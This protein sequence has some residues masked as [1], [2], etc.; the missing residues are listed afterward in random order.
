M[1]NEYIK[2]E[3]IPL[4]PVFIL[5]SGVL[6]ADAKELNN[7]WEYLIAAIIGISASIYLGLYIDNLERTVSENKK[8]PANSQGLSEIPLRED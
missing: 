8:S 6:L 3:I 4:C 7:N 5:L 1:K 2:K